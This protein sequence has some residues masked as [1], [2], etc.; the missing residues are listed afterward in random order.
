MI[1]N[2]H[3]RDLIMVYLLELKKMD[4]KMDH[5]TIELLVVVGIGVVVV[6]NELL[7][8]LAVV[9]MIIDYLLAESHYTTYSL[10]IRFGFVD[11]MCILYC[12]LCVGPLTT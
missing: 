11:K 12:V 3:R 2:I 7:P 4:L 10:C 6:D 1:V 5:L 9:D 8:L